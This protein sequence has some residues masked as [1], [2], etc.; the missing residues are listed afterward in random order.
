MKTLM[1]RL[2]LLVM[3]FISAGGIFAAE[4]K[5]NVLFIIMEDTHWNV[6]GCYGNTVCKTPNI[7]KLA[8]SGVIFE[9]AFCQ[10]SACNA[11]RTSFINGLRPA[12]TRVWH[13]GQ[14]IRDVLPEGIRG[15][16]ELFKEAGYTTIDI[17]KF[18]HTTSF[19]PKQ[20][21]VFD[22]IEHQS[23][24]EGWQGPPPI[25]NFPPAPP[26][27]NKKAKS[28]KKGKPQ[29]DQARSH[30]FSDS[31][32]DSGLEVE[33]E[34]DRKAAKIAVAHLEK[35]AA[36]KNSNKKPFFL[37]LGQSRPH[38]PYISPTK[39]A[40][41]YDPAKIPAPPAPLDTL[42]DF[43][44]VVRATVGG[45]DI[46][47]QAPSTPQE[48]KEA[49]AAYY[50][51]VTFVDE[52][53]GLVFDTL[54][55]TGL[56]KD[57]LVV[58]IGDHG[59]HLGDHN[60]WAKYTLLEGTHHAPLIVR[61]PGAKENGKRTKEL[62]EFVDLL[63]TFIDYC[64]LKDPGNLEGISFRPLLEKNVTTPWKTAVF[65][66]DH[67]FGHAVRTSKYRYVEFGE[68]ARWVANGLKAALYDIEKDPEEV[69]NLIND[70]A[71]NTVKN[72]L[73]DLLHKGWKEAL[74]PNDG[75]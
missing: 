59:V 63:P 24:P 23:R 17:G 33:Q 38:T 75:K 37:V 34:G 49:I 30:W 1:K 31:Y 71:Y 48:A 57:T 27:W 51:C 72:E 53:L 67:D 66:T 65:L 50:G 39:F 73:A 9:Q 58:L 45:P 10:G 52:N 16:P 55:K 5:P 61:V 14:R 12:T 2:L 69:V 13:N 19:A 74:P 26:D 70:P 36:D 3:V 29:T 32:G 44:Y 15:M 25:L 47:T 35:F 46:F 28:R 56:D 8:Q 11:T 60:I 20:T 64:G 42:K 6:F 4:K 21:A 7:D 22:I 68:K 41:L 62:V 43:P 54:E 40:T 18:Y